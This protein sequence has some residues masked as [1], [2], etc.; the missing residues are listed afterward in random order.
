M[1]YINQP[2]ICSL[3]LQQILTKDKS[4][5]SISVIVLLCI[6]RYIPVKYLHILMRKFTIMETDT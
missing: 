1:I 2:I 3:L 5:N 6:C 4:V